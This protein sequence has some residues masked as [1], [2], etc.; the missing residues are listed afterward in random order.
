MD[1]TEI[2]VYQSWTWSASTPQAKIIQ[3]LNQMSSIVTHFTTSSNVPVS[4]FTSYSKKIDNIILRL[5]SAISISR[6]QS[7]IE[8]I[9]RYK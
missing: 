7:I 9:Y 4:D 8:D 1:G 2:E 5:I 3:Y 6:V